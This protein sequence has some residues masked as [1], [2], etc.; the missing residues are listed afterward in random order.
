MR[1]TVRG[2]ELDGT[3]I[4]HGRTTA[5]QEVFFVNFKRS[6]CQ[7]SL[8]ILQLG[9]FGGFFVFFDDIPKSDSVMKCHETVLDLFS[10]LM[11]RG[12]I[13]FR[14]VVYSNWRYTPQS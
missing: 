10:S 7:T 2:Q 3:G 11:I 4:E 12:S 14:S 13:V 1:G 5:A 8:V 9:V 6:D